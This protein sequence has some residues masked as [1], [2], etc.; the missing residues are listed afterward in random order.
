MEK[1][2]PITAL[3]LLV[4]LV[5][6]GSGLQSVRTDSALKIAMDEHKVVP[7]VIDTVP[8][9]VIEV[10]ESRFRVSSVSDNFI[11]I[12]GSGQRDP[13]SDRNG[14]ETKQLLSVAC[15]KLSERNPSSE[16]CNG[17]G[18][19]LFEVRINHASSGERR[20]SLLDVTWRLRTRHGSFSSTWD[21]AAR[22]VSR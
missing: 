2:P 8:A 1:R 13:E 12:L 10:S 16:S 11:S 4:F 22:E 3:V 19:A 14:F 20:N 7:D 6:S 21:F 9:N 18:L 15:E 17:A 5:C